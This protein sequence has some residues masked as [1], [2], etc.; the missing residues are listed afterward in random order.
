LAVVVDFHRGGRHTLICR[1]CTCSLAGTPSPSHNDRS[2]VEFA[3]RGKWSKAC[4]PVGRRTMPRKVTAPGDG[5]EGRVS[6]TL[7]KPNTLRPAMGARYGLAAASAKEIEPA[8][9]PNKQARTRGC[10]F[11][12][13]CSFVR[14]D[15]RRTAKVAV[16]FEQVQQLRSR[17]V[18]A[19]KR[20]TRLVV[21]TQPRLKMKLLTQAC[22][23]SEPTGTSSIWAFF[24]RNSATFSLASWS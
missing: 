5:A 7:T 6:R 9:H 2:P 4:L 10:G 1:T 19:R 12:A 8:R 20:E 23:G 3:V 16:F 22:A 11:I 18:V 17:T 14:F 21:K 24:W 15:H 13:L